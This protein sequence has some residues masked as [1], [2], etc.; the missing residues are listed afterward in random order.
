MTEL[1]T[2]LVTIDLASNCIF[3]CNRGYAKTRYLTGAYWVCDRAVRN[4]LGTEILI[5]NLF[6]KH[7]KPHV[8]VDYE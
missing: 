4:V 7:E 3:S 2:T 8:A 5:N 1:L 6:I